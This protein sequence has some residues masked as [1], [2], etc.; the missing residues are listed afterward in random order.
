M[1]T[2]EDLIFDTDDDGMMIDEDKCIVYC[3]AEY[4]EA[5]ATERVIVSVDGPHDDTRN[6]C[7][8]CYEVYMI[9]VQ[10]GRWHEA[11]RHKDE[12]GRKSSQDPPVT[13]DEER[14]EKELNRMEAEATEDKDRRRG[15]YGPEYEG[16]NF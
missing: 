11:A 2:F 5:P 13:P 1:K 7:A 12:P 8:A 10:H 3:D 16:E 4:C 6:Y 15:L 9:G 14:Y